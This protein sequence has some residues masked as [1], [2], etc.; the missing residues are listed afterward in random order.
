MQGS[1]ANGPPGEAAEG[2]IALIVDSHA[3][4][5]AALARVLARL[6]HPQRRF[7]VNA[8]AVTAV[9][10]AQLLPDMVIA[11]LIWGGGDAT[12]LAERLEGIGFSGLLVVVAPPL[13]DPGLVARELKAGAPGL[14]I[15]VVAD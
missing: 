1:G 5:E 8:P 12:D 13:P 4:G 10:L 14:R 3:I 11:P 9:L 7:L 2:P 15:L 6:P